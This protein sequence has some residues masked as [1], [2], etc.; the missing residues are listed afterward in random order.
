MGGASGGGGPIRS[1]RIGSEP[2]AA[3]P[4]L[5]SNVERSIL[6]ACGVPIE[7]ALQASGS[8]GRES[9]RRWIYGSVGPMAR[10]I[11]S[12]FSAKL[13]RPITL[14]FDSLRASDLAGR[15]RAYKQLTEAGMPAK[16]AAEICAFD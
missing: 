1:H 11:E 14:G 4:E 12:E 3:L 13:D 16:R 8:G 5:R 15:A 7:V 9:W 10:L 6:A 2:A